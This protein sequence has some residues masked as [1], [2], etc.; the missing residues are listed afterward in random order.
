M[1]SYLKNQVTIVETRYFRYSWFLRTERYPVQPCKCPYFGEVGH[2]LLYGSYFIITHLVSFWTFLKHVIFCG[3]W[4][5]RTRSASLS[6]KV[7]NLS[8]DQKQDN[9]FKYK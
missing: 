8:S 4:H 3:H 7:S 6:T 9:K 2:S 5:G 1:Y